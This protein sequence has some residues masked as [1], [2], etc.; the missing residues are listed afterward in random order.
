MRHAVTPVAEALLDDA[1]R[2]AAAV[3]AAADGDAES[4]LR[5]AREEA[6]HILRE[7]RTEGR[8]AAARRA[9]A[10]VAAA[11]REARDAMLSARRDAYLE[12]RRRAVEALA[13]QADTP[14]GRRLGRRLES[15]ARA[16]V[17]PSAVVRRSGPGSLTVSATS[18]NR[19]AVIGATDLVDAALRAL[20]EQ[21]ATLWA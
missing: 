9:T 14:A 3:S 4:E 6:A 12:V 8:R 18:G 16:R 5:R 21:V 19:R 13:Q 2:Q 7:A 10:E 11:H 15:L 20:A 1:R 17:D